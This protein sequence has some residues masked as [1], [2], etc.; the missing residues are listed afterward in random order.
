MPMRNPAFIAVIAVAGACAAEAGPA[1]ELAGESPALDGEQTAAAAGA[2]AFTY[3]AVLA[4]EDGLAAER[5]NRSE[6]VCADGTRAARCPVAA[7]DW[8]PARLGA[9]EAVAASVIGSY[10]ALIRGELAAGAVLVA[11][12][13]WLAGDADDGTP[14]GVVV[15]VRDADIRCVT[16]P[17]ESMIERKL[18]SLREGLIADL[19]FAG[20]DGAADRAAAER[21]MGTAGVIVAGWRTAVDGADGTAR[22]RA[23]TRLWTR[24]AP[25]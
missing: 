6:L 1:D 4:T 17:C 9:G 14:E 12:E 25:P 23:V 18:N 3:V 15:H 10:R 13:V 21:A 11:R 19:D 5:V 16:T 24:L 22:G 20:T 2:H 7:I 8:A